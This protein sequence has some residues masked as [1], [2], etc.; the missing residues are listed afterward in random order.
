VAAPAARN[1]SATSLAV[2]K[3]RPNRR[4]TG[5][6]CQDESIRRV[7]RPS[8]RLISPR[9]FNWR[10]SSASSCSPRRIFLNTLT[11]LTRIT[12]LIAAIRYRNDPLTEAPTTF[13]TR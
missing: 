5:Y 13:V 6:I 9:E 1:S 10:S 11:M 8:T 2:S 3:P 4:P 7:N 12:R